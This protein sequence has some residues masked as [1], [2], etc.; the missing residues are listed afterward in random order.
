MLSRHNE[1]SM[2]N[3]AKEAVNNVTRMLESRSI[4]CYSGKIIPCEFDSICIHGDGKLAL[5]IGAS[6]KKTLIQK[7]FI[8]KSLNQ[9]N[10]FI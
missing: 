1:N 8:L 6:L 10:K 7:G 3:N 2:I 5:D 4:H 9:L